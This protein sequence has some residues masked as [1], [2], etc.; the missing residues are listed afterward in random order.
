MKRIGIVCHFPP[1]P[2]GMPGQAEALA[3]GLGDLGV[4]IVPIRTN[5]TGGRIL[6][7]LDSTRY[8]RSIVRWPVFLVRLLVTVPRVDVVHV[9]SASWLSF[10]LF[11]APAILL[12]RILNRWIVLHYHGG[13][14]EPFF[15]R[16]PRLVRFVARRANAILVPSPFLQTAF[17]TVGLQAAVVRNICDLS[18]IEFNPSTSLT[19]RFIV[20]RHLEPIYNVGC[21][22][23]AFAVIKERYPRA[24]LL[25]LGGGS[26]KTSLKRL[27][28]NLALDDSVQFLGYVPS[29]LVPHVYGQVSI[30][31][32]ASN[33]DNVPISILEAFAAGLPVVTTRAGGIPLLV[34]DGRNGLLVDLNDHLG[35]ARQVFRLLEEPELAHSLTRHGRETAMLHSW[36]AVLP[37]LAR[38]YPPGTFDDRAGAPAVGAAASSESVTGGP[39]T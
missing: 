8:I 35:M 33:A 25:I 21:I 23:R 4:P 31:L 18:R 13:E 27:T 10:L 20:T 32:N 3:R 15:A 29:E 11:T 14:A 36:H 38:A 39:W 2:G 12:G 5:L 9:L 6:T 7:T 1:P 28:T 24:E 34:Q 30:L 37:A 17:S 26:E 16:W 19:P 22:I